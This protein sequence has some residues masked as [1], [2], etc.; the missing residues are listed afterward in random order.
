MQDKI[1]ANPK[2]SRVEAAVLKKMTF[3][4]Q[5]FGGDMTT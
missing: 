3:V 5:N 1:L 4:L 2:N